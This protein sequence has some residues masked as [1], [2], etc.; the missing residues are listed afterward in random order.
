MQ[1]TPYIAFQ[2]IISLRHHNIRLLGYEALLRHPEHPPAALF[3][4]AEESGL[5]VMADLAA[6]SLAL[7]TAPRGARLFVNLTEQTL[8]SIL[9][10]ARLPFPARRQRLVWEIPERRAAAGFADSASRESLAAL[11][12]IL[13]GE[14]ALDDVSEDRDGLL[15]HAIAPD[16]IK[17]DRSLV[18]GCAQDREKQR[19]VLSLIGVARMS[20][21]R[22]VAEGVERAD[23]LL[24]LQE[25]GADAVQGWI[26]QP[27]ET[28]ALS[29]RSD[30]RRAAFRR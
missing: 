1:Q 24:C 30:Q 11:R 8:Q 2:P 5:A 22:V 21:A 29:P 6:V 20:K 25:L 14:I 28:G 27:F 13:G 15:L 26:V 4:K 10:G 7:A 19:R 12:C 9:D 3:R 16:W 18:S 23:D 17:L